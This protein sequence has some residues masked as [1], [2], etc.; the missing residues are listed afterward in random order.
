MVTN[1]ASNRCRSRHYR[2]KL[3]S[4]ASLIVAERRQAT[5]SNRY[6]VD[7]SK[8]RETVF[9][10]QVG[11]FADHL[12]RRPLALRNLGLR[13]LHAVRRQLIWIEN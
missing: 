11:D 2:C 9:M 8:R 1:G 7:A 6:A 13:F 5:E 12:F 10:R 4:E 3:L